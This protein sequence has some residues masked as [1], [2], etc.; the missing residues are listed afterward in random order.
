[1]KYKL[2]AMLL[3]AAMLISPVLGFWHPPED[4]APQCPH[5]GALINNKWAVTQPYIFNETV[6]NFCDNF[7]VTVWALNVTDLYGYEF[8]LA[9]NTVYFNLVSYEVVQTWPSQ[10]PVKPTASYDLS[11]PYTQI[12]VAIAPSPGVTG[13]FLLAN[14][15]FHINNDVCY[16][17][18]L[19]GGYFDL[20][21]GKMSNSCTGDILTCG[22]TDAWWQFKPKQPEIYILPA[23]INCSK[24]GT[25]FEITVWLKDIVKMTDF[26]ICLGWNGYLVVSCAN[27]YTSLISTKK[28]N[29]VINEDVFPTAWRASSNIAVNSP[30]C[31]QYATLAAASG[32]LCVDVVMNSSFPLINGTIWLFKVTFTQC[33]AWFCGAQ[34]TYTPIDV[35]T[36]DVTMENASTP[37]Y[38]IDGY[39]SVKCPLP[40]NMYLANQDVKYTY[41]AATYTFY[42]I[43]GDLD[44]SGHTGLEDLMI[45]AAYY[46]YGGCTKPPGSPPNG[47]A[48]HYDLNKN[49][50]VDVFDLVLVAKNF[51]L[52]H[53]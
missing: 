8:N 32:D 27:Y 9:W 21:G 44:G 25:T 38:F 1:M 37:I 45:E 18:P 24:I 13:D 41:P 17:Q 5:F 20:Y 31:G 3:T 50:I 19:Q 4:G 47:W 33:D 22:E 48:Y 23:A 43:P 46:G 36:H 14:L 15:T 34:P 30:V 7:F 28:S 29:V 49:G 51:C 26:H 16:M 10:F 11:S 52:D 12:Q 2:L 6:D 53:P 39:I 42:P 35:E 40:V